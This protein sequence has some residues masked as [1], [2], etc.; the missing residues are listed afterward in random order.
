MNRLLTL[1]A[2][3]FVVFVGVGLYY[4]WI[5]YH[6]TPDKATIEIQ[7]RQIEQ[8]GE[9]AVESGREL[10]GKA[11]E[12]VQRSVQD[13]RRETTTVEK[14]EETATSSRPPATTPR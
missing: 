13:D 10:V 3:L 4:R 12:S 14:R 1:L 9:R 8:A 7:T 6:K 2:I 5:T 11:A